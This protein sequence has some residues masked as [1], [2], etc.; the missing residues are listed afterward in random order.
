MFWFTRNRN[1]KKAQ[2]SIRGF[3]LESNLIIH[4]DSVD[5][6]KKLPNK[7]I[8]SNIIVFVYNLGICTTKNQGFL[9]CSI[10]QASALRN[11]GKTG[12]FYIDENI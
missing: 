5:K 8:K 11:F 4:I 7:F 6:L 1:S 12:N 9:T 10:V 2:F 3:N